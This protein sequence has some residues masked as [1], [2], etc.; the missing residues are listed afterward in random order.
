MSCLSTNLHGIT[1]HKAVT[2]MLITLETGVAYICVCVCVHTYIWIK[3]Y[4]YFSPADCEC[5]EPFKHSG[6]FT[7]FIQDNTADLH[8]MDTVP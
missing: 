4:H 2:V 6:D 3:I 5:L 7:S 1:S 8:G